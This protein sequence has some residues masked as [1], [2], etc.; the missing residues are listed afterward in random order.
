MKSIELFA[1]AGGLCL[2]VG[3]AGFEHV[4]IIE[5]DPWACETLSENSQ[6]PVICRDVAH[7]DY[8]SI[9]EKIDL[10]A[11]GPPCQ[12]FS[13]GG[14]HQ[15]HMD[16]RDMFPEA[17]RAVRELQPRTILFENVKGILRNQ[18]SNYLEYIRL[19]LRH[20]DLL[21]RQCEF[22]QDHLGRLQQHETSGSSL[23]LT[24]NVILQV[25]N[26][27]DFGVPQKRERVF[28]VGFREDLRVEWSFPE[29]THSQD[30]LY[31]SQWR[32]GKYWE[33]HGISNS[34]RP[35]NGRG[36]EC[37][38]KLKAPPTTSPW[39]TVRDALIDLPD[40]EMHPRLAKKFTSHDFIPGARV[41][42]GHAGSPY[43]APA[44]TI[45]A[46]VH[47]VPG[48]ENM[49]L[50]SDSSVRY[51]TIREC[52]RLQG[53]TDS[54]VFHGSWGRII[55][56]LG[57]AVPVGIAESV[58]ASIFQALTEYDLKNTGEKRTIELQTKSYALCSKEHVPE[59]A[60]DRW[61]PAFLP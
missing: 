48:G 25:L 11:G 34:Q 7:F 14:R 31:W 28:I 4:A 8:R 37:A 5:Q 53:F 33:I 58:A 20:P 43:D 6:W 1:G 50:R 38:K 40:P 44:K 57:N 23:G 55:K 56:Q 51:F 45:K 59:E 46:G 15:S 29:V 26:A 41:Y 60:V 39:L 21:A 10:L 22:W 13:Y 2:G 18:F 12:P 19:Q 47:G 32:S 17:I 24:Y 9:N 35:R 36:H 54:F 49:L 27:A 3:R 42:K 30:S 61:R 52:A 16:P